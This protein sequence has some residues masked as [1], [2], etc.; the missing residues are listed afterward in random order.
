VVIEDTDDRVVLYRP[1]GTGWAIWSFDDQTMRYP[2]PTRMDVLRLMFPGQSYAVELYFATETGEA[3]SD[4]DHIHGRFRGW[5]L[6]VEAPFRR[7]V[8]GFDTTD[9]VLDIFVEP[10]GTWHW[11][12]ATELDFWV[13]DGAYSHD[14]Y[15]HFYAT[16]EAVEPLIAAG[17]PPFDDEWI[18]WQP[19]PGLASPALPDGWHLLPGCEIALSSKR[20]YKEWRAGLDATTVETV[21]ASWRSLIRDN[22]AEPAKRR[23]RSGS[24]QMT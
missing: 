22:R 10:G 24:R 6:N 11:T 9:D 13:R 2:S 8:H 17:H 1:E 4:F 19:P 18:D 21:I 16:A 15:A 20:H 5:K 14:D 12:D 3:Y 23:F 7:T